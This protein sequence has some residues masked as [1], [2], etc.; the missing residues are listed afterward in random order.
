[1]RTKDKSKKA[2]RK[3]WRK[4]P[5]GESKLIAV[6]RDKEG[7]HHCA[8]CASELSAV[9]NKGAKSEKIPT[10][11]FAGHLCAK[12][13]KKVVKIAALVKDGEESLDNISL[14]IKPYVEVMVKKL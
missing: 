6:R 7:T 11:A 8:V 2:M 12:C 13:V 10:R 14:K 1:M 9:Q 4:T 5:S 3:I